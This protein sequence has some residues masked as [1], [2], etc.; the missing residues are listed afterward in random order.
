MSRSVFVADRPKSRQ[1]R[2]HCKKSLI[3]AAL[4]DRCRLGTPDRFNWLHHSQ[5]NHT[6][7]LETL[8][9]VVA[10]SNFG[11]GDRPHPLFG[12]IDPACQAKVYPTREPASAGD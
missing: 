3:P 8:E 11:A 6:T 4:T 12:A 9:R 7:G 10:V 1:A 2:P 5:P